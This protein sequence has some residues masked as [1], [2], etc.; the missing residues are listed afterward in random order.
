VH[1]PEYNP[2]ISLCIAYLPCSLLRTYISRQIADRKSIYFQWW[3]THYQTL[4]KTK[5]LALATLP[6]FL[7]WP[8]ME[9]N[10][11]VTTKITSI[12]YHTYLAVEIF[13]FSGREFLVFLLQIDPDP[14]RTVISDH[15]WHIYGGPWNDL[16]IKTDVVCIG[17]SM[18]SSAIWKR[19]MHEWVFQRLSKLHESEGRVQFEVF[20]KLTSVCFFQIARET[21]LINSM[22][23]KIMQSRA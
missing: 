3:S 21:I 13:S 2:V 10:K 22:H 7:S 11:T 15:I 20:E 16:L 4:E 12:I 23:E 5:Q 1:R 18:V 14:V 6:K 8:L 9:Y 17:N 19:K